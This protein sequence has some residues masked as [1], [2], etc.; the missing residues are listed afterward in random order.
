MLLANRCDSKITLQEHTL[1]TIQIEWLTKSWLGEGYYCWPLLLGVIAGQQTVMLLT[2]RCDNKITLQEYTLLIVK[3]LSHI[4][5][6]VI[7]VR[8]GGPSGRVF[9]GAL[10]V[11][12]LKV[13]Q[14]L[15]IYTSTAHRN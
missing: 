12:V 3:K 5:L 10:A 6:Q 15:S 4:S 13:A 14:S 8:W 9:E 7:S 2:N 1:H 11:S